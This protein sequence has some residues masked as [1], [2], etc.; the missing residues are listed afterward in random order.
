MTV[1]PQPS[2]LNRGC[3]VSAKRK[4]TRRRGAAS[5]CPSL[6]SPSPRTLYP[7]HRAPTPT[8]HETLKS[9]RKS[10]RSPP[11]KQALSPQPPSCSFPSRRGAME[12]P[13]APPFELLSIQS[14]RVHINRHA[15]SL[16]RSPLFAPAFPPLPESCKLSTSFSCL[17]WRSWIRAL[18]T[19]H[20][21]PYTRSLPASAAW[22]G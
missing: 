17:V 4:Q 18:E 14:R 5:A 10:Y 15:V 13:T 22:S 12:H 8:H 21:T 20:P 1:A 7:R 19:L 3:H 2:T 9:R 6:P 16:T 11:I